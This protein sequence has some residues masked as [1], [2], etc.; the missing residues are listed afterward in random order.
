MFIAGYR[1]LARVLGGTGISQVYPFNQVER[2]FL[3]RT[4]S[5]TATIDGHILHLD[6][7]DSLNLSVLGVNEPFT[8]QLITS[9]IP[10]GGVAV[11][12][13]ANIGY[14]TLLMARA[15]GPEGRVIAFEPDAANAELLRRNIAENGYANVIVVEAAVAESEG[16]VR[17]HL[18]EANSVNHRL[19]TDDDGRAVVEIPAVTLDGWLEANGV[20][21]ADFIKLD[22]EGA[23][24]RALAGMA[25]TFAGNPDLKM[26]LEFSPYNLGQC[27][28]CSDAYFAVLEGLGLQFGEIEEHAARV[29]PVSREDLTGRYTVANGKLTNLL[30]ARNPSVLVSKFG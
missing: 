18:A 28:G 11:D 21:R 4:R 8:T 7:H 12:I 19:S 20:V 17:L 3:S 22:I 13:G 30:A 9:L 5:R 24:I 6:E 25:R 2:W 16:T 10:L 15:V 27:G 23:E 1:F 14:Y 29:I 26:V